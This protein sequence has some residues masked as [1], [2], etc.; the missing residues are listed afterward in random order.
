[1]ASKF[2][3]AEN[4]IRK[5]AK[6]GRVVMAASTNI[7]DYE[8]IARA[9]LRDV[10][11][12][13]YNECFISDESSLSDFS[14][15]GLPEGSTTDEMS[16]DEVRAVWRKYV[17]AKMEEQYGFSV[18]VSTHLIDIFERIRQDCIKPRS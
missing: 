7:D 10:L 8:D 9:F 15:C 2:D 11:E 5:A 16:Y 17:V 3:D 12:I 1:M 6:E 18:V 4:R 13:D 14:T